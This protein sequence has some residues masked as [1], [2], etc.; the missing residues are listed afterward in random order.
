MY[1]LIYKPNMNEAVQSPPFQ[2]GVTANLNSSIFTKFV[3]ILKGMSVL[4]ELYLNAWISDVTVLHKLQL[5]SVVTQ[6]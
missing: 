1:C 2:H 3:V 5:E 4:Q 6:L